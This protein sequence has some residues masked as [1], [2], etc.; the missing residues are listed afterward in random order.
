MPIENFPFSPLCAV[1][2]KIKVGTLFV[3]KDDHEMMHD[4]TYMQLVNV[5]GLS[6][7]QMVTII[8][9]HPLLASLIWCLRSEASSASLWDV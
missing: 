3:I 7:Q 5:I 8:F 9:I 6:G 4:V 2:Y 1:S